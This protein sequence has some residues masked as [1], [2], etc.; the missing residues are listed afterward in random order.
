MENFHKTLKHI[1]NEYVFYDFDVAIASGILVGEGGG[2]CG[3]KEELRL[4]T[5]CV[6][7]LSAS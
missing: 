7:Q 2:G 1:Y 5:D 3:E 6:C 4:V